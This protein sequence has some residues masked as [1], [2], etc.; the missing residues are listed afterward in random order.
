[1]ATP[2]AVVLA[3]LLQNAVEHAFTEFEAE[4]E[5]REPHTGQERRRSVGHI[6]RPPRVN[7]DS[8]A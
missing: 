6:E 3:E 7:D 2:L 8:V 1:M 5:D 4:D